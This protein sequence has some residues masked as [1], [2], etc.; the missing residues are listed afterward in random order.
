VDPGDLDLDVDR[1]G[2]CQ[3]C[4]SLVSTPRDAVKMTP[5]LWDEGLR[6]PALA[7]VRKLGD[8]DALTD[9]EAKGG[10]CKTAR[11]IVMHLARQQEERARRRWKAMMN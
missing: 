6:E 1:I 4:L 8:A 2:I 5:I 11:A 7:A 10:R 3:A 9:L